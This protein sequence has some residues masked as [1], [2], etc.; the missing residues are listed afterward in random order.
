M[1]TT[2]EIDSDGTLTLETV[3]RGDAALRWI[4]RLRDDEPE[5]AA[6]AEAET[7]MEPLPF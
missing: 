1:K 3:D 6:K 7:W 4:A 5:P 2:L